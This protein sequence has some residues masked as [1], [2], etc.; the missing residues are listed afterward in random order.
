MGDHELHKNLSMHQNISGKDCCLASGA[1]GRPS[2]SC[3]APSNGK[4][5]SSKFNN[6]QMYI[7]YNWP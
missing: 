5:L 7:N 3:Y 1:Y 6:E 4:G 2:R